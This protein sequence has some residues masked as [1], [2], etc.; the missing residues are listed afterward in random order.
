M[1]LAWAALTGYCA[2]IAWTFVIAYVT[3]PERRRRWYRSGTGINL[4]GLTSAL[5]SAFT[6]FLVDA[7]WNVPTWLW[8]TAMAVIA[9]FLTHRLALLLTPRKG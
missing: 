8:F 2:L 7:L 5:A 9:F 4:A 3:G 6:L 1:S